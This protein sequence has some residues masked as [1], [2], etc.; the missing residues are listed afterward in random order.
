MSKTVNVKVK[1]SKCAAVSAIQIVEEDV[2]TKKRLVCSRCGHTFMVSIPASYATKFSKETFVGNKA[3]DMSL[4]L[5][6]MADGNNLAHTFELTAEYYTIGRKNNT[7]PANRPDIEI[8]TADMSMSRKH[9]VIKK[10]GNV[11]FLLKDLASKNGVFLNDSKLDADEEV[12][13]SDGDIIQLGH[14]KI[15]VVI[16]QRSDSSDGLT[17]SADE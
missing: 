11:G 6:V 16:L 9:A 2:G 3:D 12:Y 8:V 10:K 17:S 5:E 13:L 4:L 14:T 7:G 1:C 15:R